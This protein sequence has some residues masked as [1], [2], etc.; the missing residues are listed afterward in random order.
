MNQILACGG[1]F[2]I[3]LGIDYAYA[4]WL[5]AVNDQRILVACLYSALCSVLGFVSL[6]AC[7]DSW[8]AII[9]SALGHAFG[10]YLAMTHADQLFEADAYAPDQEEEGNANADAN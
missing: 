8:I 9:P 4:K 1:A 6:L 3:S 7:L 5:L 2:V 10:T